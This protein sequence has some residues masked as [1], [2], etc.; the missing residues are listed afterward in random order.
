M[1]CCRHSYNHCCFLDETDAACARGFPRVELVIWCRS[2]SYW[3]KKSDSM[4]FIF[5]CDAVG[6]YMTLWGCFLFKRKG[7]EVVF[8]LDH[9]NCEDGTYNFLSWLHIVYIV[10]DFSWF[11]TLWKRLI[12]YRGTINGFLA[13]SKNV[14]WPK[15]C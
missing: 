12:Y 8:I 5:S 15:L 2:S 1:T 11:A 4:F 14:F 9:R 10:K 3:Q 7:F 6:S 13:M